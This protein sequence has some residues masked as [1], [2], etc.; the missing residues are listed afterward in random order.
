MHVVSLFLFAVALPWAASA[1]SFDTIFADM[2]AHQLRFG[3]LA[4]VYGR[5]DPIIDPGVNVPSGHMHTIVGPD[6]FNSNSTSDQLRT[7]NCTSLDAGP[8]NPDMSAYVLCLS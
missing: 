8:S 5:T 4:I 1:A 7:A 2:Q 6:A 3:P